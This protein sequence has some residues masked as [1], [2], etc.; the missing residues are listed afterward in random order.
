MTALGLRKLRSQRLQPRVWSLVGA[1]LLLAAACKDP[2]PYVVVFTRGGGEIRVSVEVA[3]TPDALTRGLMYRTEL[4][5]DHGMLFLFDQEKNHPFWMKNTPIPLDMIF[6]SP[7]RTIVA[8]HEGAEPFSIA[9]IDSKV[10]SIAV[11]EVTRGFVAAH[12]I[13][14][15]DRVEYRNITS[16]R[17]E[18]G[19]L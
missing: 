16:P 19:T 2:G 18:K 1:I 13:A 3:D 11:L 12:K 8:L 15:G 9:P 6:L 7:G 14:I 4:A 5:P 10:P 17:L